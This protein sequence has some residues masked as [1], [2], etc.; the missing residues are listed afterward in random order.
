MKPST[1]EICRRNKEIQKM[2][3]MPHTGGSKANS[4]RR[5][6][7]FLET[8]KT[9]SRAKMFIETHKRRNGSF[10]NDEARTIGKQIVLNMTQGDTNETEVSP[11]DTIG[12][13]LGAEHSGRVRCMGMV[14]SPSNTFLN[15]KRRFSELSISSSSYGA[16]ST[17]STYLH[18]KVVHLESQL[19]GTLIALKDYMIS[20]DG[21]VP[22]QFSTLFSPQS[23]PADSEN[24]PV[25]LVDIRGSS[26]N[27]NTNQQSTA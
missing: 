8:G 9:T 1:M 21:G 11:N 17:N 16:S 14:A 2:Q 10:V 20:K 15:T 12:K 5:H 19:E 3:K 24:D 22:E 25:S 6:E 27:N 13:M 18:Q 7:L 26:I 4:R 23:E